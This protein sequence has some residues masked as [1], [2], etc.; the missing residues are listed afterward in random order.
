MNFSK[1]LL[2]L[3]S[4]SALLFAQTTTENHN[5]MGEEEVYTTP[6]QTCYRFNKEDFHSTFKVPE[7][8]FV[9]TGTRGSESLQISFRLA[10]SPEDILSSWLNCHNHKPNE[11]KCSSY[12]DDAIDKTQFF[13]KDDTMYLHVDY[14]QISPD[15]KPLLN[16][17]KSK[18]K[19]FV[20]G[21]KS[22]CYLSVEPR[23]EVE[24]VKKGSKKEKL[25]Q[26]ININ[27]VII[28]D[29][30]YHKDFAVA[31]GEDN[32]P[33]TREAQSID[34]T[35]QSVIIRSTDGG[36]TWERVE[37]M[38]YAFNHHVIV[39]DEKR[40]IVSSEIDGAGGTLQG[41][42]D[43]GKSW[44]NILDDGEYHWEKAISEG[45]FI[46]LTHKGE[47]VT[48]ITEIG[49]ILKSKD[50][51][52][53]WQETPRVQKKENTRESNEEI[54]TEN[55][56]LFIPTDKRET[57]SVLTPPRYRVDYETNTL[58]VSHWKQNCNCN[59][60]TL[61]LTYNQSNTKKGVL[62]PYWS[63]G[64]ENHITIQ[65]RDKLLFFD[66]YKGKEKLYLRDIADKSIFRYGGE[67]IQKTKDGYTRTCDPSIQYYDQ[68]GYLIKV[69]YPEKSYVIQYQDRKISKVTELNKEKHTPYLTF[70]YRYE[71][72]VVTFHN[73][74]NVKKI[75]FLKN[76]EGLLASI[77]DGNYHIFHYLYDNYGL[78]RIQSF[79]K[80][81]PYQTLLQ[82]S[83]RPYKNKEITVYDNKEE[84]N[85]IIKEVNYM[86]YTKDKEHI[87]IV[88]TLKKDFQGEVLQ[89]ARSQT[90]MY[91][92]N[93]YD[94]NNTKLLSTQHGSQTYGFDKA[95]RVNSYANDEGNISVTYSQF[96]KI[97]NAIAYKDGKASKYNYIYTDDNEHNLKSITSPQ[98]TVELSYNEHSWIKEMKIDKHHLQF[99][100]NKH[101]QPTKI[102]AVGKGE[103]ITTYDDKHEIKNVKNVFYDNTID[104]HDI[105]LDVT[106]A[107]TLLIQRTSEGAIKNYPGWVW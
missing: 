7:D 70:S 53:T 47:E 18:D 13:F 42:S 20:K 25:L 65:G 11:Y 12:N 101:G 10:L 93:Y 1:L 60:F 35:Y 89:D 88:N 52:K 80:K 16:Y 59:Q 84:E 104:V 74:T 49:T 72:T 90:D 38:G 96:Y 26:S 86:Y 6:P 102:I 14:V 3:L 29:L 92:F 2:L 33:A 67:T 32:S 34:Q 83:Y 62:G 68:N 27:D 82:F 69:E 51:G 105:A 44:E 37:D 8:I 55:T 45:T 63:L 61:P 66:A 94:A 73:T 77:L 4:S 41:S 57:L 91:R 39:L 87:C 79:Q 76:K 95:G 31:I 78:S 54:S 64:I 103:V 71:G 97:T 21:V 28:Y 48:A 36:K 99:E 106:R 56:P 46:S 19:T 43:A 5:S 107:M 81:D 15:Y 30:D 24:G 22:P 9:N 100:Y 50:G 40:A 98:G 58:T 75:T 23:I 17:I 85:G